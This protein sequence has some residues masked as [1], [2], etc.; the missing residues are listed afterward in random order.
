M[1]GGA[2][3]ISIITNYKYKCFCHYHDLN[4]MKLTLV[5]IKWVYVELLSHWITME[6]TD[7][8]S[9]MAYLFALK[10]IETKSIRNHGEMNTIKGLFKKWGVKTMKWGEGY[11]FRC[12]HDLYL[13][14]Y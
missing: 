6:T 13:P 5:L 11:T 8:T 4:L 14:M 7:V 1:V 12:R 10:C 9:F 3:I 2:W